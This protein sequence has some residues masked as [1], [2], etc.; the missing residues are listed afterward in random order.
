MLKFKLF[1][2]PVALVLLALPVNVKAQDAANLDDAPQ[3]LT[4]DLAPVHVLEERQ[5]KLSVG[6]IVVDS[7]NIVAISI[8]GEPVTSFE[9]ADT[10]TFEQE[11]TFSED[12]TEVLLVA[13]DEA[14]NSREKSFLVVLHGVKLEK[15]VDF[16]INVSLT[17][18]YEIDDNPTN[19]LSSPVPVGGV[20]FTGVVEDSEQ[21]DNR[22]SINAAVSMKL[23][24]FTANTGMA[25]VA[26]DKPENEGLGTEVLFL[27][28]GYRLATGKES[29]LLFN[30]LFTDI[31]IGGNDYSNTHTISPALE[32]RFDLKKEGSTKHRLGLD[33]VVKD[34]SSDEQTDGSQATLKWVYDSLDKEKLDSFRNSFKLGNSTEGFEVSDYTYFG[35][36]NDW[37]N[38]FDVG[39]LLNTGYGLQYRSY[40]NDDPLST[41]TPLGDTRVDYLMRYSLG[42]GWEFTP[43]WSALLNYKTLFNLS[44]KSPYVR[45]TYGI[46]ATGSF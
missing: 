35:F 14:G 19:D 8:N 26:Y 7:D 27:G 30:Y 25:Q 38:K 33:A 37:K 4:S 6:F 43:G 32:M 39:F 36:D 34:F 10:V 20:E 5:K 42:F 11:F 9:P 22:T 3:I 1:S 46:T 21:P 23:G 31:N 29:D 13:T 18:S 15:P 45:N 28:A 17:Y 40:A 2:L 24:G 44:N 16:S 12:R 41:D